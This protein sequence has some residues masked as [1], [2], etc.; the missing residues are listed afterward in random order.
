MLL[1]NSPANSTQVADG[2]IEH[3]DELG[4]LQLSKISAPETFQESSIQDDNSVTSQSKNMTQKSLGESAD[5]NNLFCH[6][7]KECYR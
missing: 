3:S 1:E 6:C 4:T 5:S 2:T 7:G